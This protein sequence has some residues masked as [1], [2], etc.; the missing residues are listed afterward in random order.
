MSQAACSASAI[1]H[2]FPDEFDQYDHE[3]DHADK[4]SIF[5]FWITAPLCKL[6]QAEASH[7]QMKYWEIIADKLSA[8]GFSWGYCSAVTRD[9][10]RWG[11][12]LSPG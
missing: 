11:G 7:A 4:E 10:W 12:W 2:S 6:P 9:G 1:A 5:F 8:A 3:R